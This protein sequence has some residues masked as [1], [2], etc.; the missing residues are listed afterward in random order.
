MFTRLPGPPPQASFFLLGP[1]GTGKSTWLRSQFPEAVFLDLLDDAV[2]RELSAQ[3]ERLSQFVPP[4][5]RDWIVVDEV[6]KA[7]ALLD[8]VH[9]LIES[10]GW[11][12]VLTGSSARK[13]KRGGANL[14]GGRARTRTM[15]PLTAEE[16][17][18]AFSLAHSLRFG[19]LPTVYV[20]AD[21]GPYL[22]AYVGTYLREE[23]M[24]EALV[25]NVGAFGR[26]LQA[27]SFSQAAVLN[28]TR[29]AEECA[30]PRKTVESHFDLLE[31]LLLGARLPVFQKRAQ[32]RMSQHPK[33]FYFDVGVFRSLRPKGPLDTPGEIDGACLETLVFQ[34]LRAHIAARSLGYDL[35]FWR[36]LDGLEVD[37]VLYG[38]AGFLAIEIKRSAHI[39][40][41]D[42]R[43]LRAFKAD[44]PMARTLLF[45][46]V[47]QRM[48]REPGIELWPL[49]EAL[50]SLGAI[51]SGEAPAGVAP[52]PAQPP[53]VPE[54]P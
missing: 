28:L 44:Y 51:L 34:E 2:F 49:G 46:G 54:R 17:G 1:R 3:P 45:C 19:Q 10:R 47:E 6:Q 16:L 13:L 26:F 11:R 22:D 38:E 42:L 21:P 15:H 14:L 4:A 12:F 29:V 41:P 27:A 25:R 36:T 20:A 8:E 5:H 30:L 23:V 53:P 35:Y 48:Y 39:R 18:P 50:Q 24:Q 33:F 9:R 52:S 43:A 37:F 31:D 40:E 32:R 7:P